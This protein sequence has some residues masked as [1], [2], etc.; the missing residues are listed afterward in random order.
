GL[1]IM[2]TALLVGLFVENVATHVI[3]LLVYT[4]GTCFT[5]PA[6]EALVSENE[7]PLRLQ[8]RIG[9]Y[10]LVWAGT[11]ALAYFSGGAMIERFGLKVLFSIPLAVHVVEL[12]LIQLLEAKANSRE[13]TVEP[14]RVAPL[15]PAEIPLNPR[16]IARVKTF[17]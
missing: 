10:N 16:P 11:G 1:S 8:L 15:D 17:L 12:S 6:L 2:A 4:A 14:P 7:P 13:S 9:V 3:V 5:W